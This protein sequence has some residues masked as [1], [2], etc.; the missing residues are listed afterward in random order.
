MIGASMVIFGP[1]MLGRFGRRKLLLIGFPATGAF[2]LGE[3]VLQRAYMGTD[4]D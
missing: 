3:T 1:R 2:L 4:E